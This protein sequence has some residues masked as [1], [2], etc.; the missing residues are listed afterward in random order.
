MDAA[1]MIPGMPDILVERLMALGSVIEWSAT[2]ESS[3]RSAFCSLVGSKYAAVVAGGQNAGWLID[4]CKALVDANLEINPGHKKAI[5]DALGLSAAANQSRNILVHGVKTGSRVP[6]GA[7]QTVRSRRRTDEPLVE[8]WTPA[9]IGKAAAAL[10]EADM[11]LMGAMQQAVS[12]QV[13][14]MDNALAWE[15]RRRGPAD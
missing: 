5:T 4:Q 12:A 8:P 13:M 10:A 2:L 15:R 6:D 11:K 7:L 3:L 1:T 14:V 9:T